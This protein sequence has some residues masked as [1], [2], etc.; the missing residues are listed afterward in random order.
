MGQLIAGSKL[1][2]GLALAGITLALGMLTAACQEAESPQP[3][4]QATGSA[5]EQATN[6][7]IGSLLPATGDLSSLGAPMITAVPLLVETVNACGGVNGAPVTLIPN[8]DDQTN[9]AAGTEG[10]TRLAT[11]DKAS[12]VVGSFA[13]SVSS[14]ALTVA[15]R[16]KI[17]LISPGSTNP[18]FSDRAA[19]GEF[20]G[21]WARTAPSDVYQAPALAKLAY[22]RGYRKVATLAINND[23]GVGFEKEFVKAF[24]AFGG[25]VV[26]QAKPTRYDPKGTTFR[27]EVTEVFKDKPDAVAAIM[28]GETGSQ[29]LKTAYEQGL[30]QGVPVLL[31]D[32][33]YAE[34]LAK[35]VGQAQDGKFIA[36]GVIGTIPGASGT[37]FADFSEI[38]QAKLKRPVQAYAAQAWDAAALLVLAAQAAKSN[39]GAGIKSKIREVANPP[40]E[41]V[42]D[43]CQALQLLKDGKEINYQGASGNVDIDDKGDVLGSYDIWTIKDDGSIATIGNVTVGGTTDGATPQ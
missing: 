14:A 24:T 15:V 13:S 42:S 4:G 21:F 32:G 5:G 3:A 18:T 34:D 6:L 41:A 25:T 16:N 43:V 37:A 29:I 8:V 1:A 30:S 23:Y 7:K 17:M 38:W 22:D 11:V 40:G 2:K 36:A 12:G 33:M 20:Q 26:N 10:M 19:K 31:T 35:R 28:Y 27:T 9:E 39:S